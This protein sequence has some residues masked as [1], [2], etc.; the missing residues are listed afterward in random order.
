MLSV[1][2]IETFFEIHDGAK[3]LFLLAKVIVIIEWSTNMQ[4]TVTVD[5]D[6]WKPN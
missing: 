6:F 3:Q 2:F 1:N 4:S 5:L